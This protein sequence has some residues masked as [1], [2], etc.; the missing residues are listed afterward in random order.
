MLGDKYREHGHM[1][2]NHVLFQLNRPRLSVS[3]ANALVGVSRANAYRLESRLAGTEGGGLLIR[4][5]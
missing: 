2:V 3:E 5:K 4:V 1:F